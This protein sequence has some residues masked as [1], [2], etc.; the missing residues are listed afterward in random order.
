MVDIRL[1]MSLLQRSGFFMTIS[2]TSQ[3]I[4]PPPVGELC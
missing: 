2:N 4:I 1:D 3:E